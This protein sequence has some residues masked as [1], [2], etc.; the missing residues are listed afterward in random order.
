MS[1][2]LVGVIRTTATDSIA[3]RAKP[4][5][6]TRL[7]SSFYVLIDLLCQPARAWASLL[8]S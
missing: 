8:T 4:T 5:C 6:S 2:A 3:T 7:M 1:S